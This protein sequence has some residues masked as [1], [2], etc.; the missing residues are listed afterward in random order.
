MTMRI[1]QL[2]AYNAQHP[3]VPTMEEA[4]ELAWERDVAVLKAAKICIDETFV[5][6]QHYNDVYSR[7]VIFPGNDL[8]LARAVLNGEY[9]S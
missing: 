3:D 7:R 1:D 4:I 8:A 5:W 2:A 9:D 6:E